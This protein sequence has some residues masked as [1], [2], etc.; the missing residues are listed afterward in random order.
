MV[1]VPSITGVATNHRP[2]STHSQIVEATYVCGNF[3]QPPK[4]LSRYSCDTH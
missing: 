1:L 4:L 2:L 3:T